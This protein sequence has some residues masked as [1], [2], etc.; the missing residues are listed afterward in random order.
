MSLLMVFLSM[1]GVVSGRDVGL[2]RGKPWGPSFWNEYAPPVGPGRGRV[3]GPAGT[4]PRR[5]ATGRERVAVP[6]P[7]VP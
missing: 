6:Q 5:G 7:G 1:L 4:G 3:A 2:G